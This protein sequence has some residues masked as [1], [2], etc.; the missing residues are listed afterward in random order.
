MK[1]VTFRCANNETKILTITICLILVSTEKTVRGL[2]NQQRT[3]RLEHVDTMYE[4]T[5]PQFPPRF[6][7]QRRSL[8]WSEHLFSQDPE[9]ENLYGR[10]DI[11][12]VPFHCATF[13]IPPCRHA[14]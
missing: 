5:P 11:R 9:Y 4:M 8:R 2:Q 10:A 13:A 1:I 14:A 3:T 12:Q 7:P 6:A